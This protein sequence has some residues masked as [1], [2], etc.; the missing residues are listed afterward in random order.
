VRI[1]DGRLPAAAAVFLLHALIAVDA[2]VVVER[3]VRAQFAQH[4]V[5]FVSFVGPQRQLQ[6]VDAGWSVGL[7]VLIFFRFFRR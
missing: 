2:F 4:A 5:S 3:L 1:L 7:A 6:P